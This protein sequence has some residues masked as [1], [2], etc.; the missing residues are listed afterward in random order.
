MKPRFILIGS[1]SSLAIEFAT[2]L[3]ATNAYIIG[4]SNGENINPVLDEFYTP[5]EFANEIQKNNLLAIEIVIY[6][7]WRSPKRTDGGE[8]T[9]EVAES[10]A[11]LKFY[12][13][14][15]KG[16][17]L[18]KFLFL[19]S[20]GAVYGNIDGIASE[21]T[22]TFPITQY[23]N[24]KVHAEHILKS[25]FATEKLLICRVSNPFGF[26]NLPKNGIGFVDIALRTAQ[27]SQ[28][29]NVFGTGQI[30][31]D[32]IHISNVNEFIYGL[33]D[34]DAFG[35]FNVASGNSYKIIDVARFIQGHVPDCEIRFIP[36]KDSPV[37][38]CRLDNTKVLN[39]V[40]LSIIN[41]LDWIELNGK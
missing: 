8:D 37:K 5:V 41:V 11:D 14:V 19:S 36:V 33:I 24:E 27:K 22:I 10:L 12:L 7:A 16:K 23:G 34:K 35:T 40:P 28:Y 21:E 3:H 39:L 9:Y 26:R 13:D 30:E 4:I 2:Y 29:V 31:R 20:G 25:H 38:A 1:N 17:M 6:F 15:F 32:F 18:N